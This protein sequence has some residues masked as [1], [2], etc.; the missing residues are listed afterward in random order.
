MFT[1][2]GTAAFDHRRGVL[3][4]AALLIVVAVTWGTGVFGALVG[5]GFEDPDSESA[6]AVAAAEDALG[7]RSNDVLA[8]YSHDELTVE[9]AEFESAVTGVIDELPSDLVTGAR[10]YWSTDAP[11]FVSED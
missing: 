10:S 5:G 6:R 9:D 7:R 4:T 11:A 1:T 8:V 3:A 2:L